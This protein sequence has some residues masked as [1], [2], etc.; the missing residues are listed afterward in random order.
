MLTNPSN[1]L[2]QTHQPH[3]AG[4]VWTNYY[5]FI[6]AGCNVITTERGVACH[7]SIA[8]LLFLCSATPGLCTPGLL[9]GLSWLIVIFVAMGNTWLDPQI[10]VEFVRY[11]WSLR[12]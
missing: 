1:T 9:I 4:G 5:C 8:L 7:V 12:H 11:L 10:L 6:V 2:L 3:S